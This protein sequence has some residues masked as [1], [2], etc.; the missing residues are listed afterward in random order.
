MPN[1][2]NDVVITEAEKASLETNEGAIESPIPRLEDIQ[3][4][5]EEGAS[6]VAE[7][8]DASQVNPEDIDLDNLDDLPDVNPED[9][10][11]EDEEDSIFQIDGQEFSIDDVLEWKSDSDN[12]S[13]WSQKNTQRAQ[14]LAR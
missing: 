10:L 11:L 4:Q 8:T 5:S 13:N 2:Y 1:P 12:K 3:E 6:E 9:Y 14:E 7:F